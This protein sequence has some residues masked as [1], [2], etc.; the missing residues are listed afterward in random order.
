MLLSLLV[1]VIDEAPAA[2][3]AATAPPHVFLHPLSDGCDSRAP[4]DEVVVCGDKQ[5][6]E[7]YRLR[8]SDARNYAEPPV[9][10]QVKLGNGT[11]GVTNEQAD[12]GGW[13]SNRVMITL[14][15]PF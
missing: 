2:A 11:A 1:M 8:P 7:R 10:A 14:K 12:I 5:A 3:T 6:D 9:R 4:A 15:F 13:P